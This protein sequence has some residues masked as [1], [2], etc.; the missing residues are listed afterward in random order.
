MLQAD[1]S[2]EEIA[3]VHETNALSEL[4]LFM[5]P[6]LKVM[7]T[8]TDMCYQYLMFD[9]GGESYL[10]VHYMNYLFKKH[11]LNLNSSSVKSVVH[12]PVSLLFVLVF[13]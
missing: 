6:K 8:Q 13:A 12:P 2:N 10:Y 9:L 4:C 7:V 11:Y 3:V 1:I 5:K